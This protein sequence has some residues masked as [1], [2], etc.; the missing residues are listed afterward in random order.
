MPVTDLALLEADRQKKS[1][2]HTEGK[3]GNNRKID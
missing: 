1:F 2:P 3:E